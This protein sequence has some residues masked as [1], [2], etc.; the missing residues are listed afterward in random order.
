MW[1]NYLWF[2]DIEF[3]GQDPFPVFL[4][5]WR[6]SQILYEGECVQQTEKSFVK[7][8]QDW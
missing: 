3:K 8:L 4:Y 6:S 5:Y 2:D 7:V 1:K